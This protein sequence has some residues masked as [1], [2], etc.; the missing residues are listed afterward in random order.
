MSFRLVAAAAVL[1]GAMTGPALT[2]GLLIGH[3]ETVLDLVRNH[4]TGDLETDGEG[5]PMIVAE[6]GGI[7]YVVYFYDCDD[8]VLCKSIQFRAAWNAPG[9]YSMRDMNEWNR[10]RRFAKAYL[11]D[12]GDPTLEMD[13]NLDFGV[14][15]DNLDDTIDW[16]RV[17]LTRFREEV[18]DR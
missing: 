1:M 16:W 5:D 13:V 10:D 15:R 14:T 3:P 12:D 4:G 8:S 17:V 9:A 7:R 18:I 2:Q 11:D 6:T